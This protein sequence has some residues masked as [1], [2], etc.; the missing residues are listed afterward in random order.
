MTFSFVTFIEHEQ[1]Q[2][3]YRINALERDT[4]KEV[5]I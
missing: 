5:S 1:T 2:T 4:G 3:L